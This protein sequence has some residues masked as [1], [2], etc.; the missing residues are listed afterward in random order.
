MVTQPGRRAAAI[1]SVAAF[2]LISVMTLGSVTTSIETPMFC[3][4][5]GALG[6]VDFV[7]NLALFMP[8]GLGLRWLIG[9]WRTATIIGALTTLVIE[10]LQWR[11]ISGRD[12]SL[13]DLLANTIGTMI[14]AW[15][16][17]DG[18]RWLNASRAEARRFAGVSGLVVSAV[19]VGSSWLVQPVQVRF[20]QRVQWK[21][22][23]RN[24][25][26][27]QGELTSVQFNGATL[28]PAEFLGP[29]ETRNTRTVT[30]LAEVGGRT[31]PTRRPAFI[32]RLANEF[33]EGF[34]VL[35]WGN[36]AAFRSHM[37]A[38]NLKLRPV[39]VGL[40]NGFATPG[41][42][43][44]ETGGG[45]TIE[46]LSNSRVIAVA[47]ATNST[48]TSVTVRRSVGLAWATLL[49]REV[50]L[51]DRW[52]PA[53]AAWL[54]ALILP[55][56]F[57]TM[58][59]LRKMPDDSTDGVAWWPLAIVVAT[60]VIAPMASGLSALSVGEWTGVL[61]GILVGAAIEHL[62]RPARAPLNTRNH[63]RTI[64]S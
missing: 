51:S 6:G 11:V 7:L 54:G 30:V 46:A 35:Q 62:V 14:G 34:A 47:V 49:P 20:P 31:P 40:Q 59:S 26:P 22:V 21:P 10:T 53:N 63:I 55:V 28:R 5:C 18:I 64:S 43:N 52:W 50:A 32:A 27:F 56:A 4:F 37:A 41:V 61:A 45:R 19:V 12:A 60:L 58:R 2:A 33:E 36:V 23:R 13:G 1:L 9:R 15:L 38:S 17:V 42:G 3:V 24:M 8:L 29:R 57:F 16:A 48:R 39:L 25:D 44:E